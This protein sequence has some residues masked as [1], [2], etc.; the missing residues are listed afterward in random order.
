MAPLPPSLAM[1]SSSEY[2]YSK[3]EDGVREQEREAKKVAKAERKKFMKVRKCRKKF[4][5]AL[6]H[7]TEKDRRVMDFKNVVQ[8]FPDDLAV[9][10]F[11]V[12]L[13]KQQRRVSTREWKKILQRNA[14]ALPMQPLQV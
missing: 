7:N 9:S 1:S 13:P 6:L 5:S 3:E 8:A 4:L 10:Y 14:P 12:F 11:L 2:S